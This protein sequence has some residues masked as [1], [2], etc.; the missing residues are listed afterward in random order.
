MEEL[1]T[2]AA[3]HAPY[4]AILG[5]L[6]LSGFGLPLPEDV[7]LIAAGYLAG[8]GQVNPWLMFPLCFLAIIGADGMV[9]VLGRLY[10]HH[11]PRLPLLNRFLTE[12]RLAKTEAMLH[13]HGG[14]FIFMARFLPG[15][16]T[17]AFFTAGSF[18]LPYWKFLLFDG[19]A[20][21]LSVPVILGLA[22]AFAEHIERVRA[23]VAEGQLYAVGGLV[24]LLAIF[25]AGKL[26]LKRRVEAA[27]AE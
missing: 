6:L 17:P 15:L 25:I 7:P 22:Y 19:S 8:I 21:V 12:K 18:K 13:A 20:A 4:V 5:T 10:G 16:R 3:G 24:L 14:K 9:F 1:L 11:V 26:L 27:T 2:Q 23:W